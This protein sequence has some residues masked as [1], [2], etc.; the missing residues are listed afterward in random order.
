MHRGSNARRAPATCQEWYRPVSVPTCTQLDSPA[1]RNAAAHWHTRRRTRLS[2]DLSPVVQPRPHTRSRHNNACQDSLPHTYWSACCPV[3]P[4]PPG[5]R[6]FPRRSARCDLPD[7][8]FHFVWLPTIPGQY[9]QW[10]FY[11]RTEEHTSEL[12][13]LRHLV[14]RLL[15]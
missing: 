8:G 11:W 13:S 12:Q 2:R 4:S 3:L 10:Y 15:L 6:N 1:N 5:W 14:C 7:G 9:G